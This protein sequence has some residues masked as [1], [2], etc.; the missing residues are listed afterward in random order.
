MGQTLSSHSHRSHKLHFR[1]TVILVLV[2]VLSMSPDPVRAQG[3]TP[4]EHSPGV[5]PQSYDYFHP[6]QSG[7]FKVIVTSTNVWDQVTPAS[8]A[9]IH[10]AG[11]LPVLRDKGNWTPIVPRLYMISRKGTSLMHSSLAT[12]LPFLQA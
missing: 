8:V 2:S 6:T 5:T 9:G 10:H 7:T 11:L 1:L 12:G 4:H 3:V